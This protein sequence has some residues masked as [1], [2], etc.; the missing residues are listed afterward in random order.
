[1]QDKVLFTKFYEKNWGKVYAKLRSA[2]LGNEDAEDVAQR[3]FEK[4]W[5]NYSEDYLKNEGYFFK[6]LVPHQLINFIV[7][8]K[9][10]RKRKEKFLNK[11]DVGEDSELEDMIE[12]I[13]QHLDNQEEVEFFNKLLR[14]GRAGIDR[15][16]R[17]NYLWWQRYKEKIQKIIKEYEK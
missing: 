6:Y 9:R 14:I 11:L 3:I 2:G 16:H 15:E 7:E 4:L 17:R 1:M 10:Y 5:T 8:E 13:K 12:F